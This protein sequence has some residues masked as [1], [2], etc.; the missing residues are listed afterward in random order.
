[1]LKTRL[2]FLVMYA[3]PYKRNLQFFIDALEWLGQLWR[4]LQSLGVLVTTTAP[5]IL[6]LLLVYY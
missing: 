2:V 1:M 6:S 3:L 4:P 5:Y